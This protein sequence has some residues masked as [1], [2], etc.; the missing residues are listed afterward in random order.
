[1]AAQFQVNITIAAGADFTQEYT[2]TSPD[3]LPVDITGYKFSA[4]LAKHPTA[5]DAAAS[6]SGSPVYK[7]IPFSTNVVSGADGLYSLTMLSNET[8]KLQEGKYVYN[9][10]MTDLDG[11]KS[12]L[13]G[14]VA[15]VDVAFGGIN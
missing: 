1:M 4:N 14:G 9:V 12:N 6:T 11:E 10:V 8:S 15:F 2:V 7:Y 3:N 5:I 13:I